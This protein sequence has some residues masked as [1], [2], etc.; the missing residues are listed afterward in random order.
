MKINWNIDRADTLKIVKICERYESKPE[1]T[2]RG[3]RRQNLLMDLTACHGNG[4]PLDL[5]KLLAADEFNFLHDVEGISRKI[6]RDT[7]RLT[8]CFLP[9]CAAKVPA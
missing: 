3:Y 1:R 7:G 5:D 2:G 4:T 8:D 9:R 6:D